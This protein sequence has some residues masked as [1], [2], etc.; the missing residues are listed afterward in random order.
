MTFIACFV[1]FVAGGTFGVA[2]MALA[3][4]A[5]AADREAGRRAAEARARRA[6]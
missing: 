1:S 3:Q 5:G 6:R 2:A 4:A